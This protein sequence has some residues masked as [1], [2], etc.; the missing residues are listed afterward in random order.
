[1]HLT[2]QSRILLRR[3]AVSPSFTTISV[4][5]LAIGIS[6]NLAIF[7]IVNAVLLRPL[8]LPDAD[9]LV[10]LSHAAPGLVQFDELP[11]SDAL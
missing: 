7:T 2:S 1:M 5:T 11:M 10:D 8:P 6:A 4:L 9:R 3:L